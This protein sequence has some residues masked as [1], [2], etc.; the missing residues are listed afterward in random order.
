MSATT[1]E[2][3]MELTTFI[4]PG[5]IIEGEQVNWKCTVMGPSATAK[6]LSLLPDGGKI[7]NEFVFI[8]DNYLTLAR[9]VIHPCILEPKIPFERIAIGDVQTLL[10]PLMEKSGMT[11]TD[12]AERDRFREQ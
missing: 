11:E 4:I 2:R 10:F 7:D 12:E 1:T 8:R 3:F 6:V 9:D 5:R